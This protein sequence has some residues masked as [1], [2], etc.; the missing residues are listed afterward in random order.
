MLAGNATCQTVMLDCEGAESFG[1]RHAIDIEAKGKKIVEASV[2]LAVLGGEKLD[3]SCVGI[4][5]TDVFV[6][7]LWFLAVGLDRFDYQVR[8]SIGGLHRHGPAHSK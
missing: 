7:D 6:G 8:R 2:R 5:F 3:A 1:Y 4:H